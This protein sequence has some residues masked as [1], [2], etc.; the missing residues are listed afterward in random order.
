MLPSVRHEVMWGN[1]TTV[2]SILTSAL[3]VVNDLFQAPA[4]LQPRRDALEH[5]FGVDD[6]EKRSFSCPF[7]ERNPCSSAVQAVSSHYTKELTRLIYKPGS[8][9]FT[10]ISCFCAVHNLLQT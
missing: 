4:V 9:K 5:R 1:V 7:G 2:S 8:R 10:N 3:D 6:L